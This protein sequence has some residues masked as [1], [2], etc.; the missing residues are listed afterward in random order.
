MAKLVVTVLCVI[1]LFFSAALAFFIA[2][3]IFYTR[4]GIKTFTYADTMCR[5]QSI[6]DYMDIC[7]T[8]R[9]YIFVLWSGLPNPNFRNQEL[10]F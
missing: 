10:Y 3:G 1:T 7:K 6:S 8:R 5:V 4:D 2:G 9:F